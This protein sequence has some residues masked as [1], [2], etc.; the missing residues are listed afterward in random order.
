MEVVFNFSS[1]WYILFFGFIT[2]WGI[3]LIIRRNSF[4]KKEIKEQFLIEV[5]GITTCFLMELFAINTGLWVYPTGNWPI[6]LWG[7]YF[8]AI[9]FGFQ[10]FKSIE[11]ILN[12]P[13]FESRFS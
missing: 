10:L 3:L 7:V 9:L 13:I 11:T 2:L 12:K 1:N 6:I 8:A 4:G 5:G